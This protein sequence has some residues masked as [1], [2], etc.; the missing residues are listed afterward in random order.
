M[1]GENVSVPFEAFVSKK[2]GELTNS[3]DIE[4]RKELFRDLQGLIASA[5]QLYYAIGVDVTINIR[6]PDTGMLIRDEKRLNDF[7]DFARY[8]VPK[9]SVYGIHSGYRMLLEDREEKLKK[10]LPYDVDSSDPAMHLT[11]S[12]VFSGPTMTDLK[13]QIEQA[14]EREASEIREAIADGTEAAPVMEIPVQ[15]SN[16]YTATRELV[17]EFATAKGYEVSHRGDIHERNDDLERLVRLFLRVLGTADRPHRACPSDVAEAMLHIARSTQTFD[18]ISIR[19]IAYGLSQLPAE[20]L[21]PD[22]PPTATKLLKTLLDADEPMGRSEI[23]EAAGISGSSYDRYINELAAWDIIEPTESEGRRRWEGHLEPW[24][25]P[26]ESSRR[27]VW[28][29]RARYGDHRRRVCS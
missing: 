11:A 28:R 2:S 20:R 7:L 1:I 12:W 8:T 16:T 22:L 21:L 9:Q 26:P 29:T 3:D 13:P 5:T 18:F 15:I 10:R 24:W 6:M 19:D 23:I 27:T 17:E 4:A 14:I 25:S